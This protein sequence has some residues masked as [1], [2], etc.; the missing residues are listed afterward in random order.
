MEIVLIRHGQPEWMPGDVYTK[1][2][3]LTSLGKLQS[4]KSSSVFE[5][6]SFDE[7]WVS[8]LQRAQETFAPFEE[9]KI[10][11][12]HHVYGW[13]Q[14]MQD[15]EEEALYGKEAGEV[16]AFFAK[17]NSQS[18]EEWAE[19]NHGK[20]MESFSENIVSN[21]EKE[22]SSR[23]I[24]SLDAEYDRRFDLSKSNVN[25][26]MIISHAG[27]MSVLLSYF[28]NMPLYAWTWRK[29][30]PRH[31]GHTTLKSS[32]ISGGHF[33]RLKEFNN[34]SFTDSDEEQTY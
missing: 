9:K 12:S 29:F 22:L 30:L 3:G 8:P 25:K 15:D 33:F 13:L 11:K 34:V 31:T 19:G 24:V 2:P 4:E 28:L 20:Y 5:E 27:T 14:E 21:L 17:R 10:A 32:G 18:F 6:N 7:I 16:Q 26:L 1:N 23:G